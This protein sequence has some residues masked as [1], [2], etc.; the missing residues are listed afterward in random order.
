MI[1]WDLDRFQRDVILDSLQEATACY[2]E[3]RADQ[4]QTACHKDGDFVGAASPEQ[5]AAR[6]AGLI[7]AATNCRRHARILRLGAIPWSVT[8]SEIDFS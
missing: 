3:R 2:W 4:L 1:G 6:D 5:I 7:L 8:P